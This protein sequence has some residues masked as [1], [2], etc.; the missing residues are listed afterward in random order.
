[1]INRKNYH[2]K[3]KAIAGHLPGWRFDHLNSDGC[4]CQLI[5]PAKARLNLYFDTYRQHLSVWGLFV[6]RY[7]RGTDNACMN[8]KRPSKDLAVDIRRRVIADYLPQFAADKLL[9]KQEQEQEQ[10]YKVYRDMVFRVS[11]SK[12]YGQTSRGQTEKRCEFRNWDA[13]TNVDIY[14]EI[15]G[16]SIDWLKLSNLTNEQAFKIFAIINE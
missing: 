8:Y 6:S 11:S 1:M 4:R 9:Y 2:R 5:G 10:A 15:Y 13:D 7:K 3:A 12:R 14:G 16:E